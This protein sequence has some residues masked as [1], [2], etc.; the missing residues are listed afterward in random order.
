MKGYTTDHL[1]LGNGATSRVFAGFDEQS[2]RVAIKK[3][4]NVQ[5]AE[6]EASILKS[7]PKHNHIIS[8]YDFFVEDSY[9]YIVFAYHPGGKLGHFKKGI[10]RNQKEAVQI[11]INIL[12]GL[13]VIHQ[14]GILHC[15]ITPHNVMIENDDPNTV[16]IID[17]G[18][19]VRINESGEYIG[20]HN[21]ATR[22]YRP[23]ELRKQKNGFTA[24]LDF[25]SDLYSAASV[26]LYMLT[27]KAP[28]RKKQ[29]CLQIV[30]QDLRKVLRKATRASKA[31]RYQ[32]AKE[33][34][35]ALSPFT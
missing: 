4:G 9:G 21:G 25:S 13:W 18:S 5:A 6:Q 23:P 24:H 31:R 7:L 32:T 8:M 11:T 14:Q 10:P 29:A 17:F 16:R 30:N 12:K 33:L 28:F 22:W 26:C 20:K 2:R 15:D 34:I 1:P 19:S 3:M 27:G 35:Q